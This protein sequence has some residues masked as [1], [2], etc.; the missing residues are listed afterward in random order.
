MLFAGLRSVCIVKN[1]DLGLENAA[2]GRRHFF[3]H[4]I[5]SIFGF[6]HF[7]P[8][9]HAALCKCSELTEVVLGGISSF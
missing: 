3:P 7:H 5:K 4:P 1:C 2:R 9:K 8:H 6:F